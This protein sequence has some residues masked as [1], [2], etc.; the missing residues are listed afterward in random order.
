MSDRPPQPAFDAKAYQLPQQD[1]VCGRLAEGKPCPVGPGGRGECQVQNLCVP[2]FDGTQWHCTRAA[3]FGGRCSEGPIP[4]PQHP[5]QSAECPHQIPPCQPVR[6]LRSRRRLVSGL[7]AAAALGLCLII[8]GGSA[9]DTE[10][11]AVGTA[12]IIS[13]GPLSAHH[14]SM[15]Q[16]CS[17]CHSVAT[18]APADLLSSAI[19]GAGGIDESYRC[20]KCH[21]EFGQ[22]A[23]LPHS[24]SPDHLAA[25]TDQ[26]S[27]GQHTTRQVLARL[28]TE[29]E[30]TASGQLACATC[31]SEHQGAEFDLTAMTN[32]QCQSCH[33]STFHSFA[34]GHPDFPEPPRGRLHFDHVTHMQL[35]FRNF[36]RLMPSGKARMQC[37][38]CHRPDAG[39]AMFRL[40]SFDVMCASCHGPQIRD[41]DMSPQARLHDLVF[42]ERSS[43]PAD[44]KQVSPFMELMLS[45][46]AA[47]PAAAEQLLT[48]LAEDGEETLRRRL[49]MVCGQST[50]AA[51]IEACVQA[52]EESHFFDAV[53]VFGATRPAEPD[54]R[55]EGMQ[56]GNWR[57]TADGQALAYDCNRH[58]DA[59]LRTWIDLLARNARQYPEPPSDDQ[60]GAFDRFLRDLVAPESTGRCLKCHTLEGGVAEGMTVNWQSPHGHRSGNGFTRFS[61]RPHLTLL[62]SEAEVDAIGGSQRC[63]TCHALNHDGFSLVNSAFR[64]EDGMPGPRDE[65]CSALGVNSVRR[66]DCAQCH[67]QT[68][69]GDNCLQCHNYHVHEDSF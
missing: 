47:D 19:G 61:H 67:T 59:V 10:D 13:P 3:A 31:H 11:A 2:W 22:H 42:I 21:H 48:D 36:E 55:P 29:P 16:G 28:L 27:A 7:T 69:A 43:N 49:H 56:Y 63:E 30:T 14:A 1:R 41:Y 24:V 32:A 44:S 50:D 17:A 26:S 53:K 52:L 33:S 66:Q 23:L 34:D 58:A 37:S 51:M 8:L 15:N 45:E 5:E 64:L 46:Q 57:L 62:S 39:A 54:S 6:S 12:A 68:L 18:R 25:T 40:E 65:A 9:G 20:L 60:S 4:D 38:D 35:H